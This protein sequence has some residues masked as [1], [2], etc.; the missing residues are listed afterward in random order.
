MVFANL[1]KKASN[2]FG[3]IYNRA[4][5]TFTDWKSGQFHYPGYNYLGPGTKVYD[6][7]SEGKAPVN[8]SDAAAMNH[9]LDYDYIGKSGWDDD[10]KKKAVRISDIDFVNRLRNNGEGWNFGNL[11]GKI[12]I[13]G[14]IILE[15]L[16]LMNPLKFL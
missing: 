9:D 13:G 8:D 14:K 11:A 12:G 4:K 15:D 7:I 6:K 1:F 2:F 10:R 16:G 5:N 3:N